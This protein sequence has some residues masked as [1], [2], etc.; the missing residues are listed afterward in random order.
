MER[1]VDISGISAIVFIQSIPIGIHMHDNTY[2]GVLPKKQ[3]KCR[4]LI[5]RLPPGLLLGHS[6]YDLF[7]CIGIT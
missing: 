7:T 2:P 4:Q 5:Y 1:I 3:T 6:G